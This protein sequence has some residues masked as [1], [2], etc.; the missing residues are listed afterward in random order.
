MFELV[1][2]DSGGLPLLINSEEY[3]PDYTPEICLRLTLADTFMF[4]MSMS[5]RALFCLC[6]RI[7]ERKVR[8]FIPLWIICK[9]ST[10]PILKGLDSLV[11]C[12][13]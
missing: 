5:P 2:D 8:R 6:C 11:C 9:S 4:T 3:S 12:S 10:S 1:C 7:T 13:C